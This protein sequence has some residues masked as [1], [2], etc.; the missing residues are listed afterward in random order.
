MT[1]V[2]FCFLTQIS[3]GSA[4]RLLGVVVP[5]SQPIPL[6]PPLQHVRHRL[7]LF[8]NLVDQVDFAVWFGLLGQLEVG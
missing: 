1:I 4:D 6:A 5:G 7:R 2:D 8:L 3:L